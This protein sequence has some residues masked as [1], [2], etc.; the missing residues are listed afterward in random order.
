MVAPYRYIYILMSSDLSHIYLMQDLRGSSN[1]VL[2]SYFVLLTNALEKWVILEELSIE[3]CQY[4][5][6]NFDL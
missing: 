6:Y 5:G 1:F 3:T 4:L 2:V